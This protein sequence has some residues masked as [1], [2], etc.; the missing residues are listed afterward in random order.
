MTGN[1]PNDYVFLQ[2]SDSQ[3]NTLFKRFKW[4]EG[5]SGFEWAYEYELNNSSFTSNQWATINSGLTEHSLDDYAKKDEIDYTA[6]YSTKTAE[7]SPQHGDK[8]I[9]GNGE[10]WEY[11]D[12]YGFEVTLDD[13]DPQK[14]TR[15]V[16]VVEKMYLGENREI[17]WLYEITMDGDKYLAPSQWFPE[18]KD[19]FTFDYNY[20]EFTGT[21]VRKTVPELGWKFTGQ[22]VSENSMV[23]YVEA[24]IQSQPTLTFSG[25][26]EDETEFS[27]E[28]VTK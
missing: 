4:N 2:T 16:T 15:E 17:G 28:V 10:M 5:E 9:L 1:T 22:M 25:E 21:A 20:G 8:K 12:V 11:G 18:K 24:E 3:G 27:F 6:I 26:Y 19:T 7:T 14:D 13:S 23:D